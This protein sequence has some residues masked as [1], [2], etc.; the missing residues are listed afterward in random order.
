M[1][2]SANEDLGTLA[3]Y[4]PL[5][6]LRHLLR[7]RASL[8]S[9]LEEERAEFV[10]DGRTPLTAFS[11]PLC[12]SL[13]ALQPMPT[14]VLSKERDHRVELTSSWAPISRWRSGTHHLWRA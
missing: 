11:N 3:E 12:A 10:L 9:A 5:T 1:C 13:R 6:G 2:F 4:D 8:G 14:L 7:T